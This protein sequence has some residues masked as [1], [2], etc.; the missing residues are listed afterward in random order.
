MSDIKKRFRMAFLSWMA[1]LLQY[2]LRVIARRTAD[3]LLFR[4]RGFARLKQGSGC[5]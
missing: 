5:Y 4:L 1:E 2:P 3:R